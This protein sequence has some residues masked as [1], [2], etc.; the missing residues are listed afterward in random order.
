MKVRL[1]FDVS[2]NEMNDAMCRTAAELLHLPRSIRR[3]SVVATY[4]LRLSS[5]LNTSV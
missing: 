4:S 5:H 3:G 2:M 1:T